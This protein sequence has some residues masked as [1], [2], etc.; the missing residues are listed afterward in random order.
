MKYGRLVK[1][2]W[3]KSFSAGAIDNGS[4]LAIAIEMCCPAQ[5]TKTM[6]CT[7]ILEAWEVWNRTVLSALSAICCGAA[8]LEFVL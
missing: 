8:M 4:F 7:T 2:E 1:N 6:Y 5:F 3:K